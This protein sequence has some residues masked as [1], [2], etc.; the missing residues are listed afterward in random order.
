MELP[1]VPLADID[2]S[3]PEFWT[4]PRDWRFG[5]FRTLRDEDPFRHFEEFQPEESPFPRGPGYRALVR[6]DDI[7]HVSRN[8][9]LFCSGNGSNIGDMPQEI[10]EFFGSMINMDDPKH[11]RLRSIVSKGFTPKEITA[12]QE[13]V[14]VRSKAVIDRMFERFPERE[15]DFVHEVAALMPLQSKYGDVRCNDDQHRK[16]GRAPYFVGRLHDQ[17]F[18]LFFVH[19]FAALRQPVHDVLNHNHRAIDNDAEV[20]RAQTEQVGWHAHDFQPH[21]GGQQRQGN[22][23]HHRQAGSHVGQEQVQHQRHE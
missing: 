14:R 10:N 20:H 4:A 23:H 1:R 22:D 3:T 18:T 6:H 2:L 13:S 5:A 21:E 12:L 9:Q 17:R 11:F 15:C 7:W 16:Q 8:P 19:A